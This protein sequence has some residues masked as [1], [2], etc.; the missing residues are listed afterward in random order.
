MKAAQIARRAAEL[1]GGDRHK[2]HG[3]LL[4]NH[5]CIAGM[6]NGYLLARIV[7]GKPNELSAE[8]VVSMMELLKIARRLNGADNVD[9]YVDGAGYAAIAGDIRMRRKN[10]KES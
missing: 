7:S 4:V 1:V 10:K 9:N 5:Q 6:W 2:Q 8:D 3:D